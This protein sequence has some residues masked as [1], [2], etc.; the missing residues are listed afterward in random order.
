[1]ARH[2]SD[3]WRSYLGPGA[4]SSFTAAALTAVAGLGVPIAWR[5][6]QVLALARRDDGGP[7]DVILVLGRTLQNDLPGPVFLA[8]LDHAAERYRKVSEL[9]LT[10]RP[11]ELFRRQVAATF[12]E[13]RIGVESR[14]RIGVESLLWA[15][16]YPH[17]DSTWPYS[18]E[19]IARDFAG[20]PEAERELILGGNAARLYG[21][22]AA[23][24]TAK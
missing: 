11:S 6:R 20:V 5:L 1:M 7:A 22:P 14:A 3:P 24:D 4:V 16:D 17:G 9:R 13:D 10:M 18:R 12:Q 2:V 8:R 21:L 19:V 15:S 23:T